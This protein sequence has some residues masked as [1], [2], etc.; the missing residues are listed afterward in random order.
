MQ[1]EFWLDR[2][3][4]DQLGWHMDQV[5]PHL[6]QHL[7]QLALSPGKRVFVPLCGKSLD[8][9]W[10]QQTHGLEVIG[11]DLAEKCCEVFF[12]DHDLNPEVSREGQ[13][14]RYQSPGITLWCGDVFDLTPE[15]L[16]RIDA[17]WDRAALVALPPGMRKA[18]A[19]QLLALTPNRPPVLC[20][21]LEYDQAERNGPPFSVELSEVEQLFGKQY[22]IATL[23]HQ[24]AMANTP[25][26][27]ERG[28]SRMM[29][30]IL[31][32]QV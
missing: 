32:M 9:L 8:M 6:P 4:N 10:L 19:G 2:W 5:N 25:K 23:T 27:R 20:W 14:I 22:R 15:H 28:L 24:D 17:V 7:D 13:F 31:L 1:P 21:T 26:Y 12:A 30:R 11:V 16:G 3:Q 18:Y 29:E